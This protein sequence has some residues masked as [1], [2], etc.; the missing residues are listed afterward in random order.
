V[1]T[2]HITIEA[3]IRVDREI[4]CRSNDEGLFMCS[5]EGGRGEP[6]IVKK[7]FDGL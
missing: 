2:I 6:A 7:S 1:D 4:M 3:P 5:V